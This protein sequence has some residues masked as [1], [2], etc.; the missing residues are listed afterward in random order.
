[1]TYEEGRLDVE[2]SSV[3]VSDGVVALDGQNDVGSVAQ[4]LASITFREDDLNAT[5]SVTIDV[6]RG[7]AVPGRDAEGTD[8][9][10]LIAV[11]EL[12]ELLAHRGN[13]GAAANRGGLGLSVGAGSREGLADAEGVEIP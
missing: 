7:G 4:L 1:M 9:V 13:V 3:D 6:E 5:V 11:S 12:R 10:G 8:G 2:V